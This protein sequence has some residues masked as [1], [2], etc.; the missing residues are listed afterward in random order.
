[1]MWFSPKLATAADVLT[2]AD[3]RRAFGGTPRFI[4]NCIIE[5]VFFTL[6]C[7]IMWFGHTMF[8]AALPFGR[9]IGWIGQTRDDHVVPLAD[10]ARDLWPHTL[11][12]LGTL[13]VLAVTHPGAIPF[14]LF[15]AGGPALS[16]PIAVVLSAPGVGRAFARWG[17]G[18][19]PEETAPPAILRMLDVPAIALA[20]PQRPPV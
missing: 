1:M 11:L 7:P 14:A 17:I 13:A 10:A 4:A 6:L 15:L 18:R 12:G 19:L 16:I 2:R 20:M 8:M 9:G 5:M 3:Q